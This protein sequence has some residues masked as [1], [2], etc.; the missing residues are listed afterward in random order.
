MTSAIGTWKDFLDGQRQ[1]LGAHPAHFLFLDR[2]T[3]GE[4][5]AYREEGK[6]D[7]GP[8]PV[9]NRY[10][11][12]SINIQLAVYDQDGY[13]IAWAMG[14]SWLMV[15]VIEVPPEASGSIAVDVSRAGSVFPTGQFEVP[16]IVLATLRRQSWKYLDEYRRISPRQR[17]KT[18]EFA[19]RRAAQFTDQSQQLAWEADIA[20]FGEDADIELADLASED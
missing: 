13:A 18:R 19:A 14:N 4:V 7:E 10:L 3:A 6:P 11:M 12:N 1:D 9:L 20:M 17:K 2:D 16:P 5:F 15:G 8:A